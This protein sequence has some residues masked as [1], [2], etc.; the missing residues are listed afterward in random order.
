MLVSTIAYLVND[1]ANRGSRLARD[2]HLHALG[3]EEAIAGNGTSGKRKYDAAG[4]NEEIKYEI[5]R[6]PLAQVKVKATLGLC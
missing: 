1:P 3:L 2:G 5:K 4:Q 6:I